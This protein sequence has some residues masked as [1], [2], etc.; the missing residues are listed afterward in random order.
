MNFLQESLERKMP[1]LCIQLGPLSSPFSAH[2][3][4]LTP[5]PERA[6]V[7]LLVPVHPRRSSLE[8][9]LNVKRNGLGSSFSAL[10]NSCWKLAHMPRRFEGE[11]AENK[12][13]AFSPVSPSCSSLAS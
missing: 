11:A 7:H 4:L 8:Q 12:V 9:P 1:V 6:G 2:F 3:H 13:S 5:L 10:K